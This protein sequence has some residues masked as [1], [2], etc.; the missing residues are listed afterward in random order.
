VVDKRF[1][2]LPVHY[3]SV[4][5]LLLGAPVLAAG[6]MLPSACGP[7]PK[8][9]RGIAYPNGSLVATDIQATGTGCATAEAVA[10]ASY[11]RHGAP[12]TTLGFTCGIPVDRPI[13]TSRTQTLATHAYACR[14]SLSRASVSFIA[15]T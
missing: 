4:L 12:Y 8:S 11:Q 10:R 3:R 7:M 6:I 9:C 1:M 2:R 14:N 13:A 5:L 15:G